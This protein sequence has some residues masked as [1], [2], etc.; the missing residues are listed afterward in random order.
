VGELG[1]N[2]Q[3]GGPVTGVVGAKKRYA[4]TQPARRESGSQAGSIT[5]KKPKG[6]PEKN[7]KPGPTPKSS[8]EKR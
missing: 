8:P 7:A 6:R 5:K 2:F 4:D 3:T 1:A